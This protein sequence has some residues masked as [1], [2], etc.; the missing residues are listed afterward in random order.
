MELERALEQSF[1]RAE[2]ERAHVVAFEP[3]DVE[4]VQEHR[5]V[6]LVALRQAGKAGLRSLER[7]HLAVDGEPLAS[8]GCEGFDQLRVAIVLEQ[9]VA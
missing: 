1:A 4:H 5:H 9:I 3:Q 8:F 7:H 6:V 2:R